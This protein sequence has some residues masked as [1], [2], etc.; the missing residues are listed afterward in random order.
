MQ[1]QDL[2]LILTDRAAKRLLSLFSPS[3]LFFSS[4]MA[5]CTSFSVRL[6]QLARQAYAAILAVLNWPHY[7]V[8][9]DLVED[10]VYSRWLTALLFGVVL[11]YILRSSV[12]VLFLTDP[13]R[14]SVSDFVRLQFLGTGVQAPTEIGETVSPILAARLTL[15]SSKAPVTDASAQLT[16]TVDAVSTLAWQYRYGY[17]DT[18]YDW[19]G[20]P[21]SGRY[22]LPG[23]VPRIFLNPIIAGGTASTDLSGY[24]RFRE[25][26]LELGLPGRYT[27]TLSS[28]GASGPV[29]GGALD[30]ISTVSSITLQAYN[31][32]TASFSPM[33]PSIAAALGAPMPPFYVRVLDDAGVPL[34]G[35]K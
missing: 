4:L 31:S 24:A 20:I 35:K 10:R 6:S 28:Q 26:S 17:A 2:N 12:Y 22:G 7:P 14:P 18:Q 9:V 16:L 3:L 30:F 34:T 1:R 23:M 8:V 5:R 11:L 32:T 29:P 19:T 27:L 33:T 13:L 15:A 21:I 25:F